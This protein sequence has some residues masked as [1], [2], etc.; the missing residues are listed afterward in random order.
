VLVLLE[1]LRI[2]IT[3]VCMERS[4]PSEEHMGPYS[5]KIL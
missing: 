5:Q 2:I 4:L 3:Y 1:L